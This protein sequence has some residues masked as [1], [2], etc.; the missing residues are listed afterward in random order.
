MHFECSRQLTVMAALLAFFVVLPPV[1]CDYFELPMYDCSAAES[2][3]AFG[4]CIGEHTS[5]AAKDRWREW[6][7]VRNIYEWIKHNSSGEAVYAQFL[8]KNSA[9]FKEYIEE[10]HGIADV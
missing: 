9:V 3:Y 1:L 10:M 6:P 2:H 4:V 5:T 8:E 7:T